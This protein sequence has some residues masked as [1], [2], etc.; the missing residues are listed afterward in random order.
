[1]NIA[2]IVGGILGAVCG[3]GIAFVALVIVDDAL[4][5]WGE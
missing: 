5:M 2:A 3:L 4:D 1:M